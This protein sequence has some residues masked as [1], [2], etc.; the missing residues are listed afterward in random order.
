MSVHLRGRLPT[1]L[2]GPGELG[3]SA[4]ANPSLLCGKFPD[5]QYLFP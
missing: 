3:A 1:G 2:T 4:D 5:R